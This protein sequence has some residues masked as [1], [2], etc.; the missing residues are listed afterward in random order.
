MSTAVHAQAP[1][2]PNRG[3]VSAVVMIMAP[4]VFLAICL[5]SKYGVIVVPT[6]MRGLI[7][8]GLLLSL[9]VTGMPIS[10]ALGCRS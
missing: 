10:I 8:A 1:I 6:S 7:I 4:L 2:P 3:A 5:L 9:F